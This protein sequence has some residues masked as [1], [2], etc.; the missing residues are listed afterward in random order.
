[1]LLLGDDVVPDFSKVGL[2][3]SQLFDKKLF[4]LIELLFSIG[5]SALQLLIFL[6]LEVFEDHYFFH[7]LLLDL[8]LHGG[9]RPLR[10]LLPFFL[11]KVVFQGFQQVTEIEE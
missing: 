3:L 8:I 10:H 6:S 7:E 4:D 11:I 2:K 1:M 5:K 9:K